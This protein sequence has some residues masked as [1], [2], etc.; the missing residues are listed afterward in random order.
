MPVAPYLPFL[1]KRCIGLFNASVVLENNNSQPQKLINNSTQPQKPIKIADV[2][3]L[4]HVSER[5]RLV[6]ESVPLLEK[7][8]YWTIDLFVVR[9]MKNSSCIEV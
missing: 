9:G 4:I 1:K 7:G 6:G 2:V 3:A 5:K 8:T